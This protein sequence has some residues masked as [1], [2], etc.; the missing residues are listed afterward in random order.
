MIRRNFDI[1]AVLMLVALLTG[2][3]DFRERVHRARFERPDLNLVIHS[4]L[5][6]G[7]FDRLERRFNE[8]DRRLNERAL[9]LQERI[10]TLPNCPFEK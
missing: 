7:V 5:D 4:E 6:R 8:L 10:E 9:R 1:L 3:S 2:L